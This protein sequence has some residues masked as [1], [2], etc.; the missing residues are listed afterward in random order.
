MFFDLLL[1]DAPFLAFGFQQLGVFQRQSFTFES[2]VSIFE[3]VGLR[4]VQGL[5]VLL[6]RFLSRTQRS[7]LLTAL[8]MLGTTGSHEAGALIA[9]DTGSPL[10]PFL[11]Q[12][13]CGL[14]PSRSGGPHARAHTALQRLILLGHMSRQ[15]SNR[16]D[17]EALLT[18][19]RHSDNGLRSMWLFL[20]SMLL[21]VIHAV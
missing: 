14:V 21:H 8:M 17:S 10:L 16:R 12:D 9:E 19:L 18:L 5:E 1:R 6:E 20:R 15:C 3:H 4:V 7:P 13:R 2:A 11:Q